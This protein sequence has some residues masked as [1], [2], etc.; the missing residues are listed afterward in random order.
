MFT[1]SKLKLEIA[2]NWSRS[3]SDDATQTKLWQ[4]QDKATML[5]WLASSKQGAKCDDDLEDYN[6]QREQID[7]C[8]KDVKKEDLP[9]PSFISTVVIDLNRY[10]F[11]IAD[12]AVAFKADVFDYRKQGDGWKIERLSA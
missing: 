12:P 11:V 8:Y 3:Q 9:C 1:N 7:E 10:N 4:Q 2:F 6:K 5:G